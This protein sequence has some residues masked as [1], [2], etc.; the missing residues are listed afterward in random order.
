[1]NGDCYEGQWEDNKAS[2]QGTK[3]INGN[4]MVEHVINGKPSTLTYNK[5]DEITG[6]WQEN[7]IWNG[8]H[9]KGGHIV[10]VIKEG[11]YMTASYSC[12]IS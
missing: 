10:W 6:I 3:V 5:G 11:K 4:Q 7:K 9:Q 8:T 12:I 2:G 1:V